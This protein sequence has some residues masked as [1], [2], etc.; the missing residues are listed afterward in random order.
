MITAT[1][2]RKSFA[3]RCLLFFAY[4]LSPFESSVV[5][6]SPKLRTM[7]RLPRSSWRASAY[8]DPA[9][10]LSPMQATRVCSGGGCSAETGAT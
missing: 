4:G 2:G 9:V 1:C 7:K 6:L 8:P 10:M 3:A 5:P